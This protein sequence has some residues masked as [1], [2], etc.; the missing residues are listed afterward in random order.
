VIPAL[1][2][3]ADAPFP[4][5]D[6][7]LTEPDGLLAWGGDL[8]PE[9]LENA[10]RS[11]IFPWY[12]DLDP[13]LW[14]SPSRRCL[15]PTDEVH[16]ARRL[17]RVLRQERFLLTMD[18]DF[19]GVVDGCIEARRSTWITAEMRAAYL[20]MHELG[21]GHSIEAWHEGRLAGGLYGLA[22]GKMFCGESMFSAAADASKV[23]LVVL[24]RALASW[25]FPWLD[26]QLRNSHLERMGAVEVPRDLFL[27]QLHA[28]TRQPDQVGSWSRRFEAFQSSGTSCA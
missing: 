19:R 21:H 3:A 27:R 8:S 28:L 25:G 12:S 26:C 14:W 17:A 2:A 7:A 11:G 16:V 5:P 4:S 9:R 13:I 6:E 15:I 24:C 20:R 1:E 23:V 18:R 22:F 10:Y